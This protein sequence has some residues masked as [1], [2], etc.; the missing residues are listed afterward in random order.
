M[1]GR[2][3]K[4]MRQAQQFAMGTINAKYGIV[5]SIISEVTTGVW[6][7]DDDHP[8]GKQAVLAYCSYV[9]DTEDVVF[10]TV[11]SLSAELRARAE[12]A[13]SD[14]IEG[15][16]YNIS[17]DSDSAAAYRA[18]NGLLRDLIG[19]DPFGGAETDRFAADA[20]ICLGA[21]R[22]CAAIT[23]RPGVTMDEFAHTVTVACALIAGWVPT[24]GR[25]RLAA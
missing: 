10:L 6:F 12:S 7:E 21:M 25:Q 18:H 17:T 24:A 22:Y 20:T 5:D 14:A 16:Q 2:K 23:S 4:E 3:K 8:A 19:V 1:F 11:N 9:A 13:A 15:I